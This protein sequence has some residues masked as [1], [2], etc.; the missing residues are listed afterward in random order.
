[1]KAKEV[2]RIKALVRVRSL[3]RSRE[4]IAERILKQRERKLMSQRELA[5]KA[6]VDRKTINRIEN[7]H[8]SPSIDTLLRIADVL[9][10]TPSRLLISCEVGK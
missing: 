10:V 6:G 8:F 4:R 2:T 1:M 9:E 5:E 3:K 7:G